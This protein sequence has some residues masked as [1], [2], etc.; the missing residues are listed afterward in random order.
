MPQ[1]P[2]LWGRL[3]LLAS[4]ALL[5]RKK[6]LHEPST[7]LPQRAQPGREGMSALCHRS[8]PHRKDQGRARILRALL[9]L[10]CLPSLFLHLSDL[11]AQ[12]LLFAPLCVGL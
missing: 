6:T 11:E 2:L 5:V 12:G 8:G 1:S 7:L 3:F 4:G 10:V 9:D